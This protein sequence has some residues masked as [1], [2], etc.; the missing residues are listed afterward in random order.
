MP[1]DLT[2]DAMQ[3]LWPPDT[4]PRRSSAIRSLNT[5]SGQS[6]TFSRT[7]DIAFSVPTLTIP[8]NP[9]CRIGCLTGKIMFGGT[10]RIRIPIGPASATIQE[11]ISGDIGKRAISA[12]LEVKL[13]EKLTVALGGQLSVDNLGDVFDSIG[14]GNWTEAASKVFNLTFRLNQSPPLFG[15]IDRID[16]GISGDEH[17]CFF[18]L[19][20]V[21]REELHVQD[22]GRLSSML[23]SAFSDS[24]VQVDISVT[25]RLGLSP[26]AW[27]ACAQRLGGGPILRA[28][29][30]RIADV[31]ARQ[32]VQS[33]LV[34]FGIFA[35]AVIGTLGLLYLSAELCN[36]ARAEGRRW[37]LLSHYC[38]GY[39][40]KIRQSHEG[41]SHY[42]SHSQT[43]S[44]MHGWRDAERAIRASNLDRVE[45][46]II[47]HFASNYD[48]DGWGTASNV[49]RGNFEFAIEHAHS[50]V[51]DSI[52]EDWEVTSIAVGMSNYLAREIDSVVEYLRA[53]RVG[54]FIQSTNQRSQQR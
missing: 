3:I 11:Y 50:R 29:T 18:F 36:S 8:L 5:H 49:L 35:A 47:Y 10:G 9:P 23:P 33:F 53:A 46:T 20:G 7:R 26:E 52:D 42:S 51:G 31:A 15:F 30:E 22:I 48:F 34:A 25:L 39:L 17:F 4:R 41:Q 13:S 28:A 54:G 6:T 45:Q 38:S 2:E 43:A 32:A 27:R 16:F 37:G 21:A 44:F 12:S 19:T 1:A 24:R 40:E 14:E